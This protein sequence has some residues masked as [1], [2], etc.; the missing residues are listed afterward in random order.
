M[1]QGDSVVELR[2][3]VVLVTGG[4][5]GIGKAVSELLGG[6]GC[7]V[8]VNYRSDAA[9][10]EATASTICSAQGEADVVQGDVAKP[11][12]IERIVDATRKR[13]GPITMLVNNAAYSRLLAP[14]EVTPDRWSRLMRTNV[15]GPYRL[16]WAVKDDMAAAGGG[17]VVNVSSYSGISPT[18]ETFA[19][20]TSKAA[21]NGFTR[22]CAL[23]L[24]PHGIRV[25]AVAPGLV[26]TDRAQTVPP[27]RQ[28]AMTA[29]IPLGRGAEPIEI[30]RVVRFLLSDDASYITG[31][32]IVAAGGRN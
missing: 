26:L 5:R 24:A 23:A 2:G 19:Y 16:T 14:D 6:E 4:G 9:A 30:A 22:G 31:E 32:V 8:M 1:T 12:D 7:R 25:N 15:D 3:R 11:D 18:V 21:L 13:F 28:A 27:E 17:A 29:G 10:A 20:G